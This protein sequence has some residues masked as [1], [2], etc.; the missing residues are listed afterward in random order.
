MGCGLLQPDEKAE[1]LDAL[2]AS[3]MYRP[4]QKSFLLY[5]PRELPSF[6]DKNIIPSSA[7]TNSTLLSSLVAAGNEAV[8][9][10]DVAGNYRFSAACLNEGALRSALER[11][12][13][14]D[15]WRDLVAAELDSVSEIYESTFNHHAYTGRSGSMYGY[16]GI[17]SIYWHMVS[18]LL[19]VVQESARDA[20]DAGA[21]PETVSRLVEHYWR[22]RS[23]LGFEQKATDFGAF[24]MDPYSHTP[25]HAGAQQPGM[26]GQ[27]KEE[28]LTRPLELG[29]RIVNGSITFDPL[30]LRQDELLAE[31]ALWSLRDVNGNERV[32]ELPANT[33]GM[34][35]CQV[36]LVIGVGDVSSG[37]IDVHMADGTNRS[38]DGMTLDHATS[39]AIFAR[40]GTVVEVRVQI[41]AGVL[42]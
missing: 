35:L 32:I 36:P 18:K 39:S 12:A 5:P 28:V 37:V 4:D 13:Q 41:P 38:I 2:L 24:P 26:T 15:Q 11:L 7:V 40:R 21:P 8:V 33:L 30:L 9:Q 34:T 10:L 16:E 22:V 14:D 1:L 6:L 29:V 31:P 20:A 42:G 27:V 19:L 17:G 25:A 3:A 23:G